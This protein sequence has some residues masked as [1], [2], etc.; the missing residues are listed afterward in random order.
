[1]SI[2]DHGLIKEGDNH[3]V[4]EWTFAD[5]TARLLTTN[6]NTGLGYVS[7]DIKKYAYQ[8]D[9]HATWRLLSTTPT[10]EQIDI[11]FNGNT[12]E[13]L[14]GDGAFGVPPGGSGVAG[15][16]FYLDDTVIVPTGTSN[17][18]EVNS[19]FKNPVTTVEVIDTIVCTTGTSPVIG[20]SYL[21]NTALGVESI[22]AG[23]WEFDFWRYVNSAT[24]VTSLAFNVYRVIQHAETVTTSGSGTSRT[25]T[26]SGG[27]PFATTLLDTGGT[28][29]SDSYLQTAQGLYRITART[30]DTVITIATPSAYV[31]ETASAMQ[32]H[33]RLFQASTG[34]IN[35]TTV[36]RQTLASTQS[37]F[38]V[39]ASD[40]MSLILFGTTDQASAKTISYVH[41]GTT[42]YSHITPP[43]AS[44]GA[45]THTEKIILPGTAYV[46]DN[47]VWSR[48]SNNMTL[49]MVRLGLYPAPTGT[50]STK[51][52]ILY[53]A[54]D[55][56]SAVT[57]FSSE[58]NAPAITASNVTADSGAPTVTALA[59]GG[60]IGIGFSAICGTTAGTNGIIELLET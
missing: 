29:D 5:A 55:P 10:W 12:T 47:I 24:G 2:A 4:Y 38:T 9:T 46:A 22:P 49:A 57:L 54:T 39:L 44:A 11:T 8:T 43:S 45:V 34:E 14:R 21:Y 41:N 31:N 40:K 23:T 17:T 1:M 3:I 13:F 15:Q 60:W 37:A 48:V 59:A 33:K 52:K 19:L 30:S 26:A 28:V 35:D 18:L 6:P 7:T 56:A 25:A 16:D 32:T 58:T 53:H 42:H 36:T 50:G 51:L 20:E 27:T